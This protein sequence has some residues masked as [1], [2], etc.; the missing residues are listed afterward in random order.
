MTNA[1]K[2]FLLELRQPII[3]PDYEP[4]IDDKD[5]EKDRTLRYVASPANRAPRH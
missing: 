4:D 5:K 2:A 1:L 3:E